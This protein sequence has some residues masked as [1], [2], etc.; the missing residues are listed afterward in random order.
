MRSL[1]RTCHGLSG[2]TLLTIGA[3]RGWLRF[4]EVHQP[5]AAL[6]DPYQRLLPSAAYLEGE[7]GFSDIYMGVPT[8]IGAGGVEAIV[9]LELTSD[10]RELLKTSAASV[11]AV[12]DIV[13]AKS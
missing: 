3:R 4:G 8:V 9:Q 7:Y 11:Q 10:E 2:F 1:E 13:K 5:Q 12:V 6:R